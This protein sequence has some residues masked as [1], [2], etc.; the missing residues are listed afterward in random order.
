ML[1]PA[2]KSVL[3]L[4]SLALTLAP[5]QAQ[6]A[7][8]A[9]SAA[10]PSAFEQFVAEVKTPLPWLNWGGDLRIRNEYLNNAITLSDTVPGH[11]QDLF[12]FRARLWTTIT[13]L[14]NVSIYGR[15]SAEPREWMKPA[16]AAQYRGQTGMEWR[17]GIADNLNVKLANIIDQP[18]TLTVG[19]QDILLGDF[20]DWWLVADG[21]PG[22]GSWTF[23][24]DS[25]RLTY[26][27]KQIKTKFDMMYLYQYAD[28]SERIPTI[29]DSSGYYLTEQN[30]KGGILYV[31][32]KSIDN[33]S[34]DGYF[35]YKGDD[36]VTPNGDNA[37]MYT[38]GA[39]VTG[40]PAQH[41]QYSVEGAYQFG[42]KQD[43]TV[44]YPVNVGA[45]DRDISAYGGKVKGT[46]LFKDKLNNQLS[47]MGEFL[48][49]DDPDTEDQDEMFDV[50]WGRW[51][52]WSEL[53]IYSYIYETSGKIAQMNNLG[54]VGPGWSFSPIKGMTFSATYNALFAQQEIPTRR[55]AQ[56]DTLFSYDGNFR[57]HY[58]QAILKHQFNKHIN[59]H[60]WGEFVWEGNYY[61]QRDLMTFLRA[62]VMF[63]F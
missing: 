15:L 63:A 26:E 29:G 13:P 46:Y 4:A 45:L 52:R 44:I 20:Y 40:T 60:L 41:W 3:C 58:A 62:E 38:F 22:D 25:A 61:A 17:Y 14:T 28:P 42:N 49:G 27:A 39:K 10:A 6:T 31:S 55:I 30:E 50:Q 9:P 24:L 57:G 54:R 56:A 51:P 47:L 37:N 23:F 11:E 48:S 59:A 53:Y 16:F 43:P 21:T 35:I 34:I 12:R 18:L 32:N 5:G 8:T 19:R 33:M 36:Q 7:A 2:L 1:K